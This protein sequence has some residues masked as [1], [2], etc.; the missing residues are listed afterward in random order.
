MEN[1]ENRAEFYIVYVFECMLKDARGSE[2]DNVLV[3]EWQQ[4]PD[5]QQLICTYL[6]ASSMHTG[7]VSTLY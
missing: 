7:M 5:P 4:E 2:A 1:P 6:L 3:K